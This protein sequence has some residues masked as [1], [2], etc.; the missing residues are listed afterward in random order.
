LI[1]AYGRRLLFKEPDA[2]ERIE[3]GAFFK[4]SDPVA[5]RPEP[6]SRSL[7]PLPESVNNAA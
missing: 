5:Q 2:L 7:T 1:N 6:F 4:E 3:A